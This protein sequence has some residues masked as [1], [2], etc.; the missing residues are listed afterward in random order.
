[1]KA[2][3]KEVNLHAMLTNTSALDMAG[4]FQLCHLTLP[5][6]TATPGRTKWRPMA[7]RGVWESR[8]G[9]RREEK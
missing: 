9:V 7:A 8:V 1:V 6:A 5:S 2:T 4:N 3:W